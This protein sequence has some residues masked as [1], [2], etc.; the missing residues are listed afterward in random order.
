MDPP[1]DPCR[2]FPERRNGSTRSRALRKSFRVFRGWAS[3]ARFRFV[4]GK[5][6]KGA[7][8]PGA[9]SASSRAIHGAAEVGAR[10]SPPIRGSA[11]SR[12]V[13]DRHLEGLVTPEV[14]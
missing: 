14:Q 5:T 1:E 2:S 13:A 4:T 8:T 10:Y 3:S 7:N 11:T 9:G 12:K 6:R